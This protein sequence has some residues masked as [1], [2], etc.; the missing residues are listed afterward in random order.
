MSSCRNLKAFL[1]TI[2][3]A[4]GTDNGVQKTKDHG[5]DVLVGG[6][7]FTDYKDHPRIA[8]YIPRAAVWSTAAGRY[9]IL[10]RTFDYYKGKLGLTDFSPE[11]QDKIAIAL[12]TDKGAYTLIQEGYFDDAVKK[13]CK[14]WASLPGAGYGQHELDMN[15]LRK[16]YVSKGGTLASEAK[17]GKTV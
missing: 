14:I 9:Q 12:I 7:L 13:C 6:K 15:Q 17:H 8:V 3:Y 5:Y 16:I 4:E 1:D 2:A 11:S 10:A